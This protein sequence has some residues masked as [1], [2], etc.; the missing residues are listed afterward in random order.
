MQLTHPQPFSLRELI[1][2]LTVGGQT[3]RAT[4]G[5][6]SA[7]A[8]IFAGIGLIL[9]AGVG[10]LGVSPLVLP[11]AGGFMLVGPAL[12]AG[13]FALNRIHASGDRPRMGDAMAGFIRAPSGLWA[14]AG[15]C[16]FLFLIWITD[17]GVLYAFM[18]GAKHLPY[19]LP[20]LFRL[21]QEV[22]VFEFWASVMGSLLAFGI[23]SISAF[24]V[25]LLYE[26]RANLIEAISI[27]VRTVFAN[28]IPSLLWGILLSLATI[29]SI[30]LLP[31]LLVVL[32]VLAYA[33]FALYRR[34]FPVDSEEAMA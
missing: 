13:F 3:Y 9:M 31:L 18:V 11:L 10:M 2:A 12:L 7:Y 22:V 33:S 32:P 29:V 4:P 19:E 24:S 17:V 16:A 23:F 25:P 1:Q 6:S 20:W 21:Q 28:L 8:A 26:R 5:P 30:L 14:I 34:V 15:I 27:S